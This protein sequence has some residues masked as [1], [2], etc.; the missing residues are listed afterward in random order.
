MTTEAIL[1]N[2]PLLLLVEDNIIA[3][4]LVETIVKQAGCRYISA[5]NGENA[6]ELAKTIPFELIITDIG[7]PGISG[8]ELTAAIREWER[9]Q[10]KKQIPIFGL[11]AH[12][13]HESE[14]CCLQAGMNRVLSKPIYLDEMQELVFQ[15]IKLNTAQGNSSNEDQSEL[16]HI[17]LFD[18]EEAMKNIGNEAILNDLL[19]LM[20]NEAIPE[21]KEAIEK[22]HANQNWQ[23]IEE[24]AHKMKSGALYCGAKRMQYACQSL[25]RHLKNGNKAPLEKLYRQLIVVVSETEHSIAL[26]LEKTKSN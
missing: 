7:L 6:L 8:T 11:T 10:N 4:R 2:A 12:T 14:T 16:E 13:L 23:Q 5:S 25:E 19:L 1:N 20:I 3:L 18:Y 15:F 22:A 24:L 9:E 17:P 21:D 26:W